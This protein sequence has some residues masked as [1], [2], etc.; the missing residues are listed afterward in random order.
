MAE[1]VLILDDWRLCALSAARRTCSIAIMQTVMDICL[2]RPCAAIGLGNRRVAHK[3]L[4][5]TAAAELTPAALVESACVL[6]TYQYKVL[7]GFV[8]ALQT[9]LKLLH[10]V[11][12]GDVGEI[13]HS[14]VCKCLKWASDKLEEA[15]C[16]HSRATENS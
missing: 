16:A 4:H 3:L 13:C 10:Q 14:C 6:C 7:L 12:E 1:A 9:P 8:C 11:P 5:N 15:T 2:T